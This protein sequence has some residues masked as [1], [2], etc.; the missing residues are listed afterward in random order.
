MANRLTVQKLLD[1]LP[2]MYN[3]LDLRVVGYR[4]GDTWVNGITTI[5]LSRL[6]PNDIERRQEELVARWGQVDLEDF[7]ILLVARHFDYWKEI[8]HSVHEG[9]LPLSEFTIRYPEGS[10]SCPWSS[11]VTA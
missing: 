11:Y 6:G 5:R 4:H 10:T 2:Q 8:L 1:G 9:A 3:G 7:K